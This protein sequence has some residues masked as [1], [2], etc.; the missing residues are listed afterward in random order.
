MREAR[1][2]RPLALAVGH[3][4]ASE[5]EK[6]GSVTAAWLAQISRPFTGQHYTILQTL[7][8]P[9]GPLIPPSHSAAFADHGKCKY[10]ILR[11]TA[12]NVNGAH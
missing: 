5:S 12:N 3:M 1:R 11:L 10:F 9:P 4:L 6:L 2:P 7:P 8:P